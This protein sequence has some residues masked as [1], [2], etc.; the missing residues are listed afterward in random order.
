M[1]QCCVCLLEVKNK[2][3][4]LYKCNTCSNTIVCK[5]CFRIMLDSNIHNNCPVCR[6][7][8][9][10]T[11][12]SVL[13]IIDESSDNNT[14]INEL[15]YQSNK[16]RVLLNFITNTSSKIKHCIISI[17]KILVNVLIVWSCGFIILLFFQ[18]YLSHV[19]HLDVIIITF[20][21]GLVFI[22]SFLNVKK[23]VLLIPKKHLNERDK[24]I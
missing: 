8:S 22:P 12:D 13:I 4:K 9:W 11:S 23:S 16:C 1:Q 19:H 20:I 24:Y 14:S 10:Y 2:R 7:E 21:V 5:N 15:N 3:N 18:P 6:T 17:I